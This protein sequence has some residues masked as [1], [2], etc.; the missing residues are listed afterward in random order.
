LQP[1][2][3]F[4]AHLHV[5]FAAVYD[6][7]AASIQANGSAIDSSA[8]ARSDVAAGENEDEIVLDLEDEENDSATTANPDEIAIED[9]DEIDEPMVAASAGAGKNLDEIQI[10]E[11]F[12]DV[13]PDSTGFD[14]AAIS[15][16]AETIQEAKAALEVNESVD[17]VETVRAA[18][19]S[20]AAEDVIGAPVS[21]S[22]NVVRDEPV[23]GPS[24]LKSPKSSKSPK[25]FTKFLALDKCGPGKDFIQVRFPFLLL[26]ASP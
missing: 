25:K 23:A 21:T 16:S 4:S 18:E 14:G 17:N 26:A 8:V 1:E 10:D 20:S 15:G 24:R 12:D 7:Q 13:E 3:W 2:Y 22:G 19:G 9:K 5:K 6:H 11:D